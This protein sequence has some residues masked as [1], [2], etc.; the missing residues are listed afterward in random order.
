MYT[1][2]LA[3][4]GTLNFKILPTNFTYNSYR[5]SSN[6]YDDL[7]TETEAVHTYTALQGKDPVTITFKSIKKKKTTIKS[8]M[9]GLISSAI[10]FHC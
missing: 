9:S 4:G 1:L 3:V 10:R 7:N 5:P 2:T 8:M 6:A